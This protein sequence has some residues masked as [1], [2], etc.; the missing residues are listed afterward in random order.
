MNLFVYTFI[1]CAVSSLYHRPPL[2]VAQGLQ[3]VRAQELWAQ[4][5]QGTWD[6]NFPTGDRTRIPC[7]ERRILNHWT[8]RAVPP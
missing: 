4:L 2:V 8:T 7:I 1:G 3:S 6:L 5:P